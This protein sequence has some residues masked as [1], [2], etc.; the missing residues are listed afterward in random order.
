MADLISAAWPGPLWAI[1][2]L[3]DMIGNA[4]ATDLLIS[5]WKRGRDARR[6]ADRIIKQY[7]EFDSYG[8]RRNAAAV[9]VSTANPFDLPEQSLAFVR[10]DLAATWMRQARRRR[11]S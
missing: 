4:S 8:S 9:E 10:R 5:S 7:F 3:P 1:V 2:N 6:P 11:R